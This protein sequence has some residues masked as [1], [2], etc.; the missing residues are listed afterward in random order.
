V[1]WVDV[2]VDIVGRLAVVVFT[3]VVVDMCYPVVATG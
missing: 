1:D 2:E 3:C